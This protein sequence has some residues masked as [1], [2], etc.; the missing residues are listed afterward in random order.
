MLGFI[1]DRT[2]DN[3]RRL[4]TLASKRWIDM[5]ALEKAEWMGD[6][7]NPETAGYT[8]PVNLFPAAEGWVPNESVTVKNRISHFTISSR[9]NQAITRSYFIIGNA[10]DFADKTL[11]ISIDG[12]LA[13]NNILHD[14][15]FCWYDESGEDV[16]GGGLSGAGSVTVSVG[17]YTNENGRAYLALKIYSENTVGSGGTFVFYRGLMV[18]FG[19]TKHDYVPYTPILPTAITKGALNYCDLNRIETAV[20][21]IVEAKGYGGLTIKTDWKMGDIISSSEATRISDNLKAITG[22]TYRFTSLVSYRDLNEI[23]TDLESFFV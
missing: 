17:D 21:E 23:E 15:G 22:K 1:T 20:A 9:N 6:P 2:Y 14:I 10:E 5:S 8:A 18:E 16:F 3:V 11:T 13:S 4:K 7:L 12:I 19:A